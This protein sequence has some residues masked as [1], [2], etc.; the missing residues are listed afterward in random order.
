MGLTAVPQASRVCNRYRLSE[1]DYAKL[2][3]QG[4]VPPWAPDENWPVH[5]N[6][7][8]YIMRPTDPGVMLTRNEGGL[9]P[10]V[11][12]WGFPMDGPNPGTNARVLGRGVWKRWVEKPAQRCLVPASAFCEFGTKAPGEKLAPQ[13]WFGVVDQEVFVFAGFWRPVGDDRRFTFATT[14]YL[15]DPD[16]HVVGKVHPKAMPVILHHEDLDRW[17]TAPSTTCSRCRRPIRRSLCGWSD[18]CKRGILA[19]RS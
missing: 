3:E 18:A 11:M 13:H 15:G 10:A 4:V 17:L 12:R 7:F 14:G 16:Q 8:K 5:P 19:S 9:S 6:P 1:G 2:V